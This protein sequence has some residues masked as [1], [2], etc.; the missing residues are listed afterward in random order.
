MIRILHVM[1]SLSINAGM[2]SVV[3][4]YYRRIDRTK[5]QFD[6]WYFEETSGTH[7]QEIE[8]LG[9]HV[10]YMPYRTFLPSDQKMIRHFFQNHKTEYVAVHCHPIWSSFV[11]SKEA[12]RSG[13]K[14]VIQH[15]HSTRYSE[16]MISSLRNRTFMKMIGR[17]ATDYVACNSE[18][19]KLFGKKISKSGRVF[20][21]PNAI[22]V[23]NYL[24]DREARS[25][26]RNELNI[27]D[28]ALVVG[29]VGRLS[30]EK[31]QLFCIDVYEKIRNNHPN[32]VLLIVGEGNMRRK[33]EEYIDACDM[34]GKVI[35]TGNRRDIQA[36]L[37]SFDV[38]LMP[39]IFEGTPVSALEARC[40][41]LPCLL[42]DSI[43]RSVEMNGMYYLS[44][45][46][47][48]TVWADK[49]LELYDDNMLTVRL[50]SNDVTKKGFDIRT[51]ANDLLNFYLGLR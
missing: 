32:S 47:S 51:K 8:K 9:G 22:S 40:S 19:V 37:S 5:I 34:Q 16:K 7:Q 44:I 18:A 50:D 30:Q 10:Y 41:G 6:F 39:S 42:S 35:M 21:L 15:A 24:F 23:D 49:V 13:I 43:T 29:T 14:H 17:Y 45:K 28:D 12:K 2:M 31:N 36:I 46:H 20:V 33:L 3:M 4:N 27:S 26:V 1:P 25:L 38:F 11:I 48:P